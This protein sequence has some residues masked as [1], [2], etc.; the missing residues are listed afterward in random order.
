MESNMQVRENSITLRD[1]RRMSYAEYGDPDGQPVFLIHG[2]PGSRLTWSVMA[3]SPSRK[4]LRVIAPDRPGYGHSDF[5]RKGKTITDY[6]DDVTQLANELGIDKFALFGP[7]G[8]GPY[9]LTCAWK[10]PERLTAVGV[11]AS[12]A[13][14]V[15]EATDGLAGSIKRLYRFAN[16]FPRLVRVQMAVM[17]LL[18]KWF[19]ALYV[20]AIKS[21]FS[22]PDLEAYSRLDL[23]RRLK[24]DRAETY[25]RYGRGVAY[26]VTIP[27]NWPIPLE[28][29][30]SKV[31]IWQGEQDRTVAPAAGRYFADRI[32]DSELT[33]IP[34]A[35]HIWIFEHLNEMLDVLVPE[36]SS[37]QAHGT[38][39]ASS[40]SSRSSEV[41]S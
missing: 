27:G 16:R 32:P 36:K 26:D 34:D 18:V 15:P 4:G 5:F 10:I 2:I 22:E 28:E 13:P 33:L 31:H 7:S 39:N 38:N 25:R 20:R 21:E 23:A 14:N 37:N 17:T 8:G 41:N 30:S 12:V 19:P 9:V 1:G 11:F 6:P 35:G 40:G 29:I 3:S 24:V